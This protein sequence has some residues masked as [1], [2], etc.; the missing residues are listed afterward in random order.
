MLTLA[1]RAGVVQEL[2]DSAIHALPADEWRLLVDVSTGEPYEALAVQHG[3]TQAA[4]RS[5]V[6][7]IRA[8]LIARRLAH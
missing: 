2:L 8:S 7:R 3:A 1:L 6:S 4:L 5:R